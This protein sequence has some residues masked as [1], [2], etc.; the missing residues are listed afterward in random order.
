MEGPNATFSS[1]HMLL[2]PPSGGQTEL[3]GAM[4]C[5]SKT[6]CLHPVGGFLG[7]AVPPVYM[8]VG[9][10]NTQSPVLYAF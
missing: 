3:A 10:G 5:C 9:Y 7:S 1:Q 2:S 4:A 8:Q 6:T